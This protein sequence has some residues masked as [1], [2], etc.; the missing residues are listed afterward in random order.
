MKESAIDALAR[1]DERH[2]YYLARRDLVRDAAAGAALPDAGGLRVLDVGCGAAGTT[3]FLAG[4]GDVTAVDRSPAA[5]RWMARRVPGGR[6]VEGSVVDLDDLLDE[7]RFDLV[8]CFGMLNHRSIASPDAAIGALG[9][10]VSDGGILILEEPADP[11]LHRQV[12]VVGHT[13]RR[14]ELPTL[15]EAVQG[16]GLEVLDA[17]Y[18]HAWAWPVARAI[19][20]KQ[21]RYPPAGNQ[22]PSELERQGLN[23]VAYALTRA[24]R[25]LGSVGLRAPF[26]TGCWVIARARG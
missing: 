16:A 7:A 20:L 4:W 26:G 6:F 5:A 24:E 25:R 18:L 3:S 11:R 21:R 19:A 15:V 17:R 23:R 1:V 13:A 9:R 10:R 8:T 14:F 12:D 22:L 2:W